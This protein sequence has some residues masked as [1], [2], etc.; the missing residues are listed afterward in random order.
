MKVF[1]FQRDLRLHYHNTSKH[2]CT[3]NPHYQTTAE[4]AI[5]FELPP[6]PPIEDAEEVDF[7]QELDGEEP[8]YD[9][10]SIPVWL[11]G[12]SLDDNAQTVGG[13]TTINGAT[14]PGGV[15]TAVH[16]PPKVLVY[17]SPTLRVS[18]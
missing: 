9:D 18:N 5:S 12:N 4:E 15:S 3:P 10:L 2:L 13:D 11:D 6:L 14:G 7:E 16:I 17:H 8:E 1:A